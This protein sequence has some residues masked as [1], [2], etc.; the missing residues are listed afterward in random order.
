[1]R[2]LNG[3]LVLSGKIGTHT[4]PA[5]AEDVYAGAFSNVDIDGK[6]A[7]FIVSVAAPGVTVIGRKIPAREANPF[8]A[9][10]SS[11]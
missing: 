2:E 1:V 10:L 3:G 5:Y 11:R 8:A 4:S 7:T 6:R 9:P